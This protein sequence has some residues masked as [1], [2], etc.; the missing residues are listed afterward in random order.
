MGLSDILL[1]TPP[2]TQ[3]NTPYPATA[4]LKGFLHTKG[5]ASHQMDLGIEV[6]LRIFSRQGLQEVFDIDSIKASTLSDNAR[7]IYTL[8]RAYWDTI[9]VVIGFLQGKD[10]TLARHICG[11]HFLPQ[12]GRFS[13]LEDLEWA[14]GE[15]GLQDKAKYLATLYVEDIADFI[16]E[17]V[18]GH[19]GFS[20]YAE[21]L[22]RSANTF[23]K[24]FEQLQAPPTYVD[25]IT[26]DI[27]AQ[28]IEAQS[29]KLI[30]FTI[31]FP[32]NLYSALRCGQYIKR[33]FTSISIAIGGGYPNTELR[34]VSD[35]RVFDLVDYI[36]LD[37]GELPLELIIDHVV[38]P[39]PTDSDYQFFKRTFYKQAGRVIY[40]NDS[41]R[42]DY[43][44]ADLGTPDY[45]DL[46]LD[47]YISVIEVI[48]PMHSLWSDGRWNKLTMAHGCYWGKCTFCDIS[49]DYI[50][51][52]EPIAASILVDRVEQLIAQ[53]A[54][55]G[56]HFVDEA[57]P[58]SLMKSFALEILR[59]HISITWWTNI[60]FEKH[61]TPDLCRLLRLSGC[62]A[63]SGGLEV[64]SDRLL[65]L[66]DKG[67][68]VEQVAQVTHQLQA[69]GIMV[70]AYLMYGYPSQSIQETIDS[71]EMVRQLFVVG[72]I[73]SGFWHRFAMTAHSPVGSQPE[74]Y[75]V[76]PIIETAT[77]AHNDIPFIDRTGIDHDRFG[78]GLKKSLYNYMHGVGLDYKLSSWFDFDIPP[79]S[80]E[81]DLIES[82]IASKEYP[83]YKGSTIVYWV[84]TT[85]RVTHYTKT[86]RGTS[87]EVMQ[88]VFSS[89]E[90]EIEVNMPKS[91]GQWLIKTLP[92]LAID[93]G[94]RV[95][96]SS[97]KADFEI[98]ISD[99]ELFWYSKQVNLVRQAGLLEL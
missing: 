50:S 49:L 4:Y 92:T 97:L 66:I 53:T 59:R 80:V 24:L 81:E 9:D 5:I 71:L 48:N 87:W 68:T 91:Q 79:T 8:R 78:E 93:V 64:A 37:D 88:L 51:N 26:L 89:T 43:K 7:R 2:F 55:R 62:I 6:I 73:R 60:R 32:G 33:Y 56:F 52:Y 72:A 1:V 85:P 74:I 70:H 15:L 23:D 45:G 13:N 12:A 22:G 63:V 36:C 19:F 61:F 57:A 20:R 58:P 30:C 34:S 11:G 41:L 83:S 40:N 76:T 29:P 84:G 47:R 65:R 10:P 69:Q 28:Y 86:K 42:T 67:V 16:V 21:Q 75:G 35:P 31:P 98:D 17:C 46:P 54:T 14:F 18:D 99:F 82:Y 39:G 96:L 77:F 38:N 90:G 27:L 25:K 44:Q 3:L 94:D 95:L